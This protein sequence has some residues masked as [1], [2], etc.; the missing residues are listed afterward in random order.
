MF[1]LPLILL[2]SLVNLVTAIVES[3][4]N[5]LNWIGALFFLLTIGI[6]GLVGA[7]ALGTFIFNL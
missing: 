5:G 3:N 4:D 1:S 6:G 2:A 7:I